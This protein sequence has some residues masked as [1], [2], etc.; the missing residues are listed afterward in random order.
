MQSALAAMA[1]E[2]TAL[3]ECKGA[4]R[5]LFDAIDDCVFLENTASGVYC[6]HSLYR[7]EQ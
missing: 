5:G 3:E 7:P 1:A 2:A 4:Q 6:F